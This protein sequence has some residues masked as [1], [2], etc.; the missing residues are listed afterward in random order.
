MSDLSHCLDPLCD[1]ALQRT[2]SFMFLYFSAVST[3]SGMAHLCSPRI[4]SP[5]IVQQSL[6]V[7]FFGVLLDEF[8]FAKK[9]ITDAERIPEHRLNPAYVSFPLFAVGSI[10]LYRLAALHN[11]YCTNAA[12]IKYSHH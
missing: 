8:Q 5:V 3:V 10:L 6:A 9:K 1:C 12:M 11:S 4:V 2:H 7:T